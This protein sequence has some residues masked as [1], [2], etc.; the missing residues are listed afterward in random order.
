MEIIKKLEKNNLKISANGT[1]KTFK[2]PDGSSLYYLNNYEINML[3]KE[4]YINNTY[5]KHNIKLADNPFIFDIGANIGLFSIISKLK[6]PKAH[7]FSFEPSPTLYKYLFLNTKNF[8]PKIKTFQCGLSYENKDM[9]FYY[10][11]DYSLMSSF[12][13][14][15]MQDEIVIQKNIQ[16]E[17]KITLEKS[18]IISKRLLGNVKKLNCK[19]ITLSYFIKQKKIKKIDLLKIDAEKSES[20]ILKGIN[21]FDW[22]KIK[23]IIIESHNQ[24]NTN[25]IINHLKDKGYKISVYQE[26]N[27]KTTKIKNIIAE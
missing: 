20:N 22:K 16:D 4:I 3:Y 13:P 23:K 1:E 6:Y 17:S 5:Y 27:F 24:K 14:K 12:F 10:Y 19:T 9:P 2:M 25:F 7:I 26:K 15:T 8:N 11:P 18:K 21:K